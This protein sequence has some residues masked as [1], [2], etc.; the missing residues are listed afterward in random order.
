M[1][2]VT[3]LLD[4]HF[5][6]PDGLGVTFQQ[7]IPDALP[8]FFFKL[9]VSMYAWSVILKLYPLLTDNTFLILSQLSK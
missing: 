3:L 9:L 4:L 5:V 6:K 8:H 1:I 7:L 2:I